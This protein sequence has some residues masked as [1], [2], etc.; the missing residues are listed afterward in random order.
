MSDADF[1]SSG[2]EDEVEE[3]QKIS[4]YDEDDPAPDLLEQL[5]FASSRKRKRRISSD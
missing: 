4:G 3:A 1:E 2:E 5:E